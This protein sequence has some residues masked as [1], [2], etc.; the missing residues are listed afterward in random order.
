M[1]AA[2]AVA[3]AVAVALACGVAYLAVRGELRAEVDRALEDQ[4]STRLPPPGHGGGPRFGPLPARRGGPT[5]YIQYIDAG[6]GIELHGSEDVPIPVTER[7]REVAAGV[8]PPFFADAEVR[9]THARVFTVPAGDGL[10]VQFGRSLE[11]SDAVLARLRL[12][13][14]LVC[15]GGIA[16]AIALGRL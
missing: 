16:L 7:A 8:A 5:P 12:I 1:T 3:V 13:L 10:A 14:G 2:V 15:L 11:P 9:G 4:L 6:Q